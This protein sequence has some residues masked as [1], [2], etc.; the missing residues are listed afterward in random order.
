MVTGNKMPMIN[1]KKN[2]KDAL[3]IMNIKKLGMIVVTRN[4]YI[5]GL[6]TDGDLRR[7]LRHFSKNQTLNNLIS[8]KPM[9]VNE[10]MPASKVLA[11]MN[12]KNY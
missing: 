1:F 10:N 6:I 2:F 5:Q 11:I 7:G 3:K 8:K 9:V 12:E 4:N